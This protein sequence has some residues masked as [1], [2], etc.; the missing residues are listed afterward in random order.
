LGELKFGRLRLRTPAVCGCVIGKNLDEMREGIS[1]A[2]KQGADLVELRIDDLRSKIAWEELIQKNLPTMLANHPKRD[3]GYFS[4]VEKDRVKMLLEGIERGVSCVDI[5]LSTPKKLRE[6]VVS[7][8]K[9]SGVTVLMSHHD[10]SRTPPLESLM[11]LTRD[12]K[13][14]GCDIAKIVTLAKS[15]SDALRM[16][17]FL[18]Q[19]QG[20]VTVPIVAFAMGSS[21]RI[22]R[23]V[24]PIFG[25]PI[26]YATAWRKTGPG[27]LDVTTMKQ[28]TRELMSEEVRD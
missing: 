20:K 14:A 27:Q 18:V 28:W 13:E 23:F 22:T 24:A 9:K 11:K 3:G 8:A 15:P 5:E 1:R 26:I 10:V 4:G 17:D 2:V 25:S 6:Q 12:S 16:L 7:E 19:A 21:G